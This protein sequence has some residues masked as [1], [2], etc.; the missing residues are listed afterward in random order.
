[1]R[2]FDVEVFRKQVE[3]YKGDTIIPLTIEQVKVLLSHIPQGEKEA[4]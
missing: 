3:N 2:K 4:K 1:M